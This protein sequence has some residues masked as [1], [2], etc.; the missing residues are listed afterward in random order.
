MTMPAMDHRAFFDRWFHELWTERNAGIIDECV[1]ETCVIHGLPETQH[2]RAAFHQFHELF[3]RAFPEIRI[4]VDECVSDGPRYA[5][6]CTGHVIDR[7]G[8]R[9]TFTGGG[10]GQIRDGQIVEAWNQWDFHGILES[11]GVI[12]AG[13]VGT[14]FQREGQRT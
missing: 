9:H 3:G 12:D 8:R 5:V 10:M 14:A 7:E 11:M 1:A 6:R 2:G 4:T 13:I